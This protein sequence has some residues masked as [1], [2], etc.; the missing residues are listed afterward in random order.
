MTIHSTAIVRPGATVAET[1]QVGPYSVIGEHVTIGEGT[2]IGSHCVIE[3]HTQIG[4]DNQI[5]TGVVLGSIPQDLKY[6]GQDTFLQIGDRNNF[7]EYVTVN[8]GTIEGGEITRVGSDCH[9]MAYSHIAHDCQIGNSVIMANAATL[10]G[11]VTLEDKVILGGL[12]GV[13]QF[14]RVGTFS[15][16]G[17]CTKL[18]QDIVP[19]AMVDGR[20]SVIFGVN[21]EGLKRAGV[22]HE[23]QQG[24]K[25]AFK[26]LF[27]S[28]LPRKEA[29]DEIRVQCGTLEE[30]NT[31]M[32]FVERSE[33]G[34]CMRIPQRLHEK[35]AAWND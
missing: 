25:R 16:V 31:L 14:V 17:G 18:T 24:L 22:S 23:T 34:I 13:H 11:H 20:P 15:I 28:G 4:R 26:I 30:I 3:G 8:V 27:E 29:L 10:A 1:V 6:K 35:E 32:C 2:R 5:Y 21:R 33:R 19:Y 7:R 9:I 12:V